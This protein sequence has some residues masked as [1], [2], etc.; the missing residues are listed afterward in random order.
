MGPPSRRPGA[1]FLSQPHSDPQYKALFF[2]WPQFA[3]HVGRGGHSVP[4]LDIPGIRARVNIRLPGDVDSCAPFPR[5]PP[6]SSLSFLLK[7]GLRKKGSPQIRRMKTPESQILSFYRSGNCGPGGD[8]DFPSVTYLGRGRAQALGPGCGTR[9]RW[10]TGVHAR[11]R[12]GFRSRPCPP[13]V[14]PWVSHGTYLGFIVLICGLGAVM[15]AATQAGVPGTE[16]GVQTVS[17]MISGGP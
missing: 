5:V 9:A 10:V 15:A 7:C 8:R 2:L 11:V 13:A 4:S 12:L 6:P 14:E 1:G 17:T 3:Q 16:M